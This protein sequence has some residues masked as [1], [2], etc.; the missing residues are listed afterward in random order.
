MPNSGVTYSRLA[1]ARDGI[2]ADAQS[3]S[4]SHEVRERF[5]PQLDHQVAP[6]D[7]DCYLTQANFIG[8]LFVQQSGRYQWEDF[9]FAGA[10]GVEPQ[11]QILAL[12]LLSQFQAVSLYRSEYSL[13]NVLFAQ[14]LGQKR[15]RA[16]LHGA[17]CHGNIAM[18][19]DD[20]RR[21]ASGCLSQF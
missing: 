13:K 4:H 15:Y 7:L 11:A 10:Q 8:N 14:R 19:S 12:L 1:M 2:M 21:N 20:D 17:N 16:G 6:V 9:T 5:R 18:T 3:V